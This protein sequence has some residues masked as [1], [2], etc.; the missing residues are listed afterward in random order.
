MLRICAAGIRRKQQPDVEA[1][2]SPKREPA[3]AAAPLGASPARSLKAKQQ[4]QQQRDT[5]PVY[6]FYGVDSHDDRDVYTAAAYGDDRAG[7]DRGYDYSSSY[8]APPPRSEPYKQPAFSSKPTKEHHVNYKRMFY[9]LL[10]MLAMAGVAVGIWAG[11][12]YGRKNGEAPPS[13]LK[14]TNFT[15]SL[16]A[17]S[18]NS[19][20][21]TETCTDWFSNST[22]SAASREGGQL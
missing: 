1:P 10:L 19:N 18:R 22:V 9:A 11:V 3:A 16:A 8:Q 15:M 7:Y 17:G 14:P 2:P 12:T 4:Q 21:T 13:P 20:G 6:D 5:A